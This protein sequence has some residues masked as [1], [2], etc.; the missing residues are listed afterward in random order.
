MLKK[1]WK[2]KNPK[3]D[4]KEKSIKTIEETKRKLCFIKQIDFI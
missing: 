1:R 2:K 4:R 3:K